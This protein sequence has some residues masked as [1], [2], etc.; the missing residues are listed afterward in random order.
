MSAE[1]CYD[2]DELYQNAL[3]AS[4]DV[5]EIVSALEREGLR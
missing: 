2:A 5:D 4:A 3:H 1:D